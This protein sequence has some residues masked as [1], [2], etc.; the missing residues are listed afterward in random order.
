MPHPILS[1]V[2]GTTMLVILSII[3][4][5]SISML[6]LIVQID[7]LKV[8]MQ[9][10]VEN[11]ASTIIEV[12][13][14][15][16]SSSVNKYVVK[17][18]SI[19]KDLEEK[20]FIISLEKDSSGWYVRAHMPTAPWINV[21]TP[22]NW[23]LESININMDE[24]ELKVNGKPIGV[25]GYVIYATNQLRSGYLKPVV[26]CIKTSQGVEIGLGFGKPSG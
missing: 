26:W 16:N 25:N 23:A 11:I 1:H 20:G 15:T 24:K 14:I 10:V 9:E 5:A 7:N 22:L 18:I 19:P 8:R 17:E 13:T 6:V 2:I 3:I 21:K 12:I 4:V